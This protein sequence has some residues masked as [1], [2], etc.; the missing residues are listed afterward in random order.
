MGSETTSSQ[1]GGTTLLHAIGGNV[2]DGVQL[3]RTV[4][5]ESVKPGTLGIRTEWTTRLMLTL[6]TN[7]SNA[8][9][10][11]AESRFENRT[12]SSAKHRSHGFSTILK[13]AF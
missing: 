3:T 2:S 10:V 1:D 11:V 8:S 6:S 7:N 9:V 4:A 5:C 13:P 12:A